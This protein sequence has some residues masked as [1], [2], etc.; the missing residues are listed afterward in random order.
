M[1]MRLA[2]A[3]VP[4]NGSS[5][6]L[7]ISPDSRYVVAIGPPGARKGNV[8]GKLP[9]FDRTELLNLTRSPDG[10]RVAGTRMDPATGPSTQRQPSA[11]WLP[12][13]S[14]C[15]LSRRE[16]TPCHAQGAYAWPYNP[17][18]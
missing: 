14:R 10:T 3:G 17:P 13:H 18:A 7:L 12:S 4:L 16:V 2:L 9:P 5:N 8:I 6:G 1:F 15:D 11:A